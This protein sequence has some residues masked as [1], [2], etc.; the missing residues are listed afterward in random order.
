VLTGP[1]R[2]LEKLQMG[3]D[4]HL[5]IEIEEPILQIET[6]AKIETKETKENIETTVNMI[7]KT[8]VKIL[9]TKLSNTLKEPKINTKM[10]RL[11]VQELK[12]KLRI[13]PKTSRTKSKMMLKT[14]PR[15]LRAEPRKQ[16]RKERTK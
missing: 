10:S 8:K 1:K 15:M 9:R 6:I 3:K 2:K 4:L 7:L 5:K 16:P 13:T 11:K 12:I 14:M